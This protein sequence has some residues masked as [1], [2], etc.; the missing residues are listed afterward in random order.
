MRVVAMGD[1][2]QPGQLGLWDVRGD[3]VLGFRRLHLSIRRVGDLV[4]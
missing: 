1:L 4:Y 3:Y 2:V